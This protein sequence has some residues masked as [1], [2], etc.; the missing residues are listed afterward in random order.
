MNKSKHELRKKAKNFRQELTP[1]KKRELDKAIVERLLTWLPWKEAKHVLLYYPLEF[2]I[3]ICPVIA[4]AFE[5]KKQVALPRCE[6]ET[7]QMEFYEIGHLS[8]L[9]KGPFDLWEPRKTKEIQKKQ[10]DVCLLPGLAFDKKGV[11]LGYGKGY[12]DRFL[13]DYK[14]IKVGAV[15]DELLIDSLPANPSDI[16]VD[17]VITEKGVY[18]V[19]DFTKG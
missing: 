3:D 11:R 12:Y 4:K 1:E 18:K 5:Q 19:A 7:G 10:Y 17:Y 8:D 2:E 14:G 15:Y 13:A 9:E 6:K 16:G